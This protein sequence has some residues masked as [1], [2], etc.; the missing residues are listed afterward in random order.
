[1]QVCGEFSSLDFSEMLPQKN[2]WQNSIW[3]FT[4]YLDF[5]QKSGHI[6]HEHSFPVLELLP[7]I[8]IYITEKKKKKKKKKKTNLFLLPHF[9]FLPAWNCESR[10]SVIA[11]IVLRAKW[12]SRVSMHSE[13]A[14]EIEGLKHF[15][16]LTRFI[17]RP[18]L[19]CQPFSHSVSWKQ[20]FNTHR[21]ARPQTFHYFYLSSLD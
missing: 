13:G 10:C 3:N 14:K 20:Y 15:P 12:H 19:P 5:H 9:H 16:P 8:Y 2:F 21:S 4:L 17:V 6:P 11:S 1:M 7:H 18:F